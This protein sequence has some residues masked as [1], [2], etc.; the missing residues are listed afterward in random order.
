MDD[1]KKMTDQPESERPGER[2]SGAL[3]KFG[4]RIDRLLCGVPDVQN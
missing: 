1:L 2:P 4:F 3:L